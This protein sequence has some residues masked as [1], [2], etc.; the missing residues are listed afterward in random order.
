MSNQQRIVDFDMDDDL[1]RLY[2]D[3][4]D[5]CVANAYDIGS[6]LDIEIWT[7]FF[8]RSCI[9]KEIRCN[10]QVRKRRK[11]YRY[12]LLRKFPLEE[13]NAMKENWVKN[14][15][16]PL[17]TLYNMLPKEYFDAVDFSFY[18]DFIHKYSTGFITEYA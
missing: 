16:K 14:Y 1:Y 4:K 9:F 6:K 8:K 3:F 5:W 7:K 18:C 10:E 2:F 17:C 11:Y 13:D 12:M 15:K